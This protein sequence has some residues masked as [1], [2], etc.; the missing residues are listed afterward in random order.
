M[1]AVNRGASPPARAQCA[2]GGSAHRN[3]RSSRERLLSAL[4]FLSLWSSAACGLS[5]AEPGISHYA[6]SYYMGV[7]PQVIRTLD[8]LPPLLRQNVE[9]HLRA[10]LGSEFY[11]RLK[12]SGGHHRDTSNPEERTVPGAVFYELNFSFSLPDD[13]ISEYVALFALRAN[14]SVLAEI[15]LPSCKSG[16]AAHPVVALAQAKDLA[17]LEGF[18]GSEVEIELDYSREH[19]CLF[20]R[21]RKY[22]GPE[23][24][25][26]HF[27]SFCVLM[28]DHPVMEIQEEHAIL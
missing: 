1:I 8:D 4:V 19:D 14:G 17:A 3:G 25:R 21:F 7:H 5:G 20:W 22:I 13:G 2:S 15:D 12:F 9:S 27:R 16:E 28:L 18:G 10:R 6:A 23:P 26:I 24:G 11:A